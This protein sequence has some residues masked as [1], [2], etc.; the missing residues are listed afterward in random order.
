MRDTIEWTAPDVARCRA[1]RS[2]STL[3]STVPHHPVA[4]SHK[5]TM[6]AV[7]ICGSFVGDLLVTGLLLLEFG[8]CV[9]LNGSGRRCRYCDTVAGLLTIICTHENWRYRGETNEEE[10]CCR[11]QS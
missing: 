2:G 9:N 4:D 1:G 5:T 6:G 10:S 8:L 11:T 3:C 7:C